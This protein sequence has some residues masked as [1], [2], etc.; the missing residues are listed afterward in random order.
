MELTKWVEG[1]NNLVGGKNNVV[2]KFLTTIRRNLDNA[3]GIS[4]AARIVCVEKQ[5]AKGLANKNR[6]VVGNN[7]ILMHTWDVLVY[8]KPTSLSPNKIIIEQV[9][10][11]IYPPDKEIM[12]SAILDTPGVTYI[13]YGFLPIIT[14]CISSGYPVRMLSLHKQDKSLHDEEIIEWFDSDCVPRIQ[15]LVTYFCL[16][17]QMSDGR[18]IEQYFNPHSKKYLYKKS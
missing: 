9:H 15:A 4:Y 10:K 5:V 6:F 3:L 7:I 8:Q 12:Q 11:A 17:T 16:T 14:D 18:E 1:K 13:A 2:N